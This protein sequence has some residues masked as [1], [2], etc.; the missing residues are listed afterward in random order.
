V[1][2]RSRLDAW[3]KQ[4]EDQPSRSE[5]I[6]R[7]LEQALA[8]PLGAFAIKRKAQQASDLADRAA[9]QIVNKSMP[10]EE[11]ERRKRAVIKGPKE[12]RD[13]REDQPKPK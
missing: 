11:Q 9:E 12:F 13:I 1:K 4:Q 3:C 10:M 5:A 8:D 7:I 6:R 2:L